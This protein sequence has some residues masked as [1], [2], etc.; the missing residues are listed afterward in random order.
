ME[1]LINV[2]KSMLKSKS[3]KVSLGTDCD[4]DMQKRQAD[5]EFEE[6]VWD[7]VLSPIYLVEYTCKLAYKRI[8]KLSDLY[9]NRKLKN[10]EKK[11][12]G[13]LEKGLN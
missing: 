11:R 13:G 6:M 9:N 7:A 3:G 4:E 12:I 2:F 5:Y 8:K 10:Q 1:K